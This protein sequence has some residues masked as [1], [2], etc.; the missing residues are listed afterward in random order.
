MQKN[1]GSL[2]K[3]LRIIVAVIFGIL[4]FTDIITG[5]LGIVLLLISIIF[6]LTSLIGFCPLYKPLNISTTKKTK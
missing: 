4:Y 5:T 2:D 1:M 3:S 6:V